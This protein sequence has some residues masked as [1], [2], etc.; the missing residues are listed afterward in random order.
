MGKINLHNKSCWDCA[1]MRTEIDNEENQ[2]GTA[3][4]CWKLE[5]WFDKQSEDDAC[6]DF[7]EAY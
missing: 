5:R 7:D 4:Y 2:N 1:H 3:F 6:E